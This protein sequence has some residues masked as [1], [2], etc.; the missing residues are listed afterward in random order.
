MTG[1]PVFSPRLLAIWIAAA[2][3]AF[4]LSLILLLHGES[5]ETTGP[6][7]FSVSAIGHA[8]IAEV[9]RRHGLTVIKSRGDPLQRLGG[10][11]LLVL[12]EPDFRLPA[13][14]WQRE[15]LQAP[16]VLL[17]LPKWQ[18]E[19]DRRKRGWIDAAAPLPH[20]VPQSILTAG[21]GQGEVVRS[22]TPATFS[23]N[24]IGPSPHLTTPVQLV[25][26][27]RLRPM[28]A[29]AKGMLLGQLR[30]PDRRVWVL[31][32]PDTVNNHG[33]GDG[34]GPF[35][36]AMFDALRAGQIIVFDETIHGFTTPPVNVLSLL[37]RKDFAVVWAQALIALGLL[38]WAGSARFG[39]PE[40][41]P[42]AL[43][44]GKRELARNTAGLFVY[45]GAQ[46]VLVRRYV[47]ETVLDVARTLHMPR[48][49]PDTIGWL[50]HVG[51]ERGVS[52]D[53]ADL[54][55]RAALLAATGRRNTAEMF[56]LSRD[57]WQW[58]QEMLHGHADGAGRRGADPRRGPQG[59]GGAG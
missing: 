9:L 57:A 14:R 56:R 3:F 52:L 24:E 43:K 50:R 48:E 29:S 4:A 20:F 12:A 30:D 11:G 10:E 37:T 46:H 7:T 6:S 23:R 15:L 42:P 21:I 28:V 55:T 22:D 33:L 16:N 53:C 1:K 35:A 40:T 31:S 44:A 59:G 51:A 2:A 49:I 41:A 25:K 34:N 39:A 36:T 47:E 5:T 32:D 54:R 38:L 19:P 17:I 58:K 26:S 27:D 13:D 45:A 8:G 18:G